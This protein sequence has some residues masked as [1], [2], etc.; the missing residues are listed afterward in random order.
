M[1]PDP[2]D[3]GNNSGR[4]DLRLHTISFDGEQ[5]TLPL[6][7]ARCQG[8]R[9]NNEADQALMPPCMECR[10]TEIPTAPKVRYLLISPPLFKGGVCPKQFRGEA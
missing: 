1:V 6:D 5:M 4:D 2:S 7:V 3:R 10:R 9:V 8:A